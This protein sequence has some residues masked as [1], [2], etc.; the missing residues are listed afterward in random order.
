VFC[1]SGG[2]VVSCVLLQWGR[3]RFVCSADSLLVVRGSGWSNDVPA[4]EELCPTARGD[5]E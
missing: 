5:R 2:E 3:G 1:C 4:I